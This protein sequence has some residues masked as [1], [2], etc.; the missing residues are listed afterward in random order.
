[1]GK[2][3][4]LYFLLGYSQSRFHKDKIDLNISK[5]FTPYGPNPRL[6]DIHQ[7]PTENVFKEK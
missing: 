4:V 3:M 7:L 2:P 5:Y 1:M 6:K